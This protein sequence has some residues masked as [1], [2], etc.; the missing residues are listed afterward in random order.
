MTMNTK[1]KKISINGL[2]GVRSNLTLDLN[3]KS[4]LIYGDNGTGKS[5]ISDSLE[6]YYTNKVTH[7][8]GSEIELLD[9]LRNTNLS[10]DF[11]SS[12]K[13]NFNKSNID[14]EKKLYTKSGKFISEVDST[15]KEVGDYLLNS[16]N[17]NLLLRYQTLR[18]FVD[19]TKSDKLKYLSDIIGFSDLTRTKELLKNTFN[20]IKRE[21]KS[22]NFEAQIATQKQT[23]VNKIGASVSQEEN[24]YQI[25]NEFI[26]TKNTGI[27]IKSIKDI[28]SVLE[29][30]KNS[31][32]GKLILELKFLQN[33]NLLLS[34][35]QKE[36]N[37][38]NT[39]YKKYYDEFQLI[40]NDAEIILQIYLTN[41]LKSGQEVLNKKYHTEDSCPLCLQP[42]E[43]KDLQI[44]IESRLREIEEL[45]KKKAAFD[46]AKKSIIQISS[47]RL[48]KIDALISNELF[49]DI[50]FIKIKTSITNLSEKISE[51]QEAANQKVLNKIPIKKVE[52]I[53]LD[54]NDFAILKDIQAQ[55][56]QIEASIKNND[57]TILYSNISA[58]K[59]AFLK[60]K[61]FEAEQ[62]KLEKQKESI[63]IIYNEFVKKQKES[64][65]SFIDTFSTNIN[66][67]YQYMN[68][69]ELFHEIRIVTIGEEDELNGITIEYKYNDKWS[70]PPQKYFSE[71]HLNCLGIS[72]FL[73]SIN[74]FNSEN[75][76]FVLDDV[77]SSFDTTHR[78]RFAD[79]VFEKFKEWQIIILT[80]EEEWFYYIQALAKKQNW[81][82]NEVKWTNTEGTHIEEKPSDLKERI[83][84]NL[85][86]A[87]VQSLGNDIRRYL[88]R[89]LKDICY[90]L[91]VKV[92]F[93]FNNTNE[94]R[95]IDE[96]LN[97]LKSKIKKYSEGLKTSINVLEQVSSSTVLANLLSHDNSFNP[98]IG[99]L[100]ALWV[101]IV[102]F[103]KLFYCQDPNCKK[104][105]IAVENL[106]TINK[107]IRCSCGNTQYH[108][109]N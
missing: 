78:K 38:L 41:L 103:E 15:S 12:I 73:A 92:N 55:V 7:L 53:G 51:F 46:N 28:E 26:K 6:W 109:S 98:K 39:E 29:I 45:T 106:D 3:E 57:A 56:K 65:Q 14:S 37:L 85:A 72:F 80:H 18:G 24:L 64:L 32:N 95:M 86:N 16:N 1:I 104:P 74:A 87:E 13:V 83:E 35:L 100:K 22:Q 10:E 94:K 19:Q 69:A 67:Y 30:L 77:I 91:E 52:D 40:T 63:E 5:S 102:E 89:Q 31:S 27:D 62:V 17:E 88:E 49:E 54:D 58:S 108:W 81:L 96:L 59:E 8:S 61:I 101:D 97:N 60:I 75:K 9:A 66:E 2:R 44:Q 71:S 50:S 79:L 4:I 20:S 23:L 11:I 107:K 34:N 105:I 70:A 33:C 84:V 25:I 68:P 36:V 99:D 42:K 90:S 47:D 48:K 82:I 21:I 43:I 76:F 93:K